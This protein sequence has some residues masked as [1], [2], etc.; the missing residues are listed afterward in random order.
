MHRHCG[1][2]LAIVAAPALA[3]VVL[4]G[5]AIAGPTVDEIAPPLPVFTPT[6]TNWVPKY[7]YPYDQTGEV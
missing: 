7:P 5:P 6:P 3:M 2:F 4:A 1:R